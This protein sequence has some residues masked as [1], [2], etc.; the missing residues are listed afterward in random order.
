[1][2]AIVSAL[3][4]IYTKSVTSTLLVHPKWPLH[5]GSSACKSPHSVRMKR[6]W[7]RALSLPPFWKT[8]RIEGV[9]GSVR[10]MRCIRGAKSFPTT[11]EGDIEA[12][13]DAR[14]GKFVAAVAMKDGDDDDECGRLTNMHSPMR[15]PAVPKWKSGDFILTMWPGSELSVRQMLWNS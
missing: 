14:R 6:N 10:I 8:G 2:V 9:G 7:L 12:D 1:M 4:A 5:R 15:K 11:A 13:V 3:V